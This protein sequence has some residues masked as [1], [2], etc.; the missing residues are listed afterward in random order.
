[1]AIEFEPTWRPVM[2][3]IGLE[4]R[5]RETREAD[6]ATALAPALWQ[7]FRDEAIAA[8]IPLVVDA[9]VLYA[10][11][12]CYAPDGEYSFILGCAVDERAVAPGGLMKATLPPGSYYVATSY[13]EPMAAAAAG[14]RAAAAFFAAPDA[15]SRTFTADLEVHRTDAP[16][17]VEIYVAVA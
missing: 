7:R 2:H 4:V 5:T 15:P 14:W 16:R 12:T 13:G 11:R 6:A 3:V 8:R 17:E 10:V 1:M 9:T